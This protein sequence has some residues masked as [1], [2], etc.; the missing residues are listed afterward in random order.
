MSD[1]KHELK[2]NIIKSLK[3]KVKPEDIIN[4]DPLFNDG[5]GLD[6]IAALELL[7]MLEESYGIILDNPEEEKQIMYSID[8]LAEFVK[9]HKK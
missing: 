5:L 1:F 9:Q 8:T 6:S 4:E 2:Q 3:L 7:L